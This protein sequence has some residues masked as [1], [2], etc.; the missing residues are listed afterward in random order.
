MRRLAAAL[1]AATGARRG[2]PGRGGE[3][4]PDGARLR[5]PGRRHPHL[6]RLRGTGRRLQRRRLLR[7]RASARAATSARATSGD[8]CRPIRITF[9]TP[10]AAVSL[11]AP[12]APPFRGA[13]DDAHRAGARRQGERARR[14]QA[15]RRRRTP[16]RRSCSAPADGARGDPRRSTSTARAPELAVDD[17]AYSEPRSPTRRSPRGPSGTVTSGDGAFAFAAN[18]PATGFTC[19]LDGAAS[20]PC[21]SPFSFTGLAD[22]PHTFSV[23]ATDRWGATDATPAVAHVDGQPPAA[24]AARPRRR[25]RARRLRQLPRQRQRRAGRCRRRQDRRRL[26]GAALRHDPAG[27]GRRDRR[28]R[29]CPARCS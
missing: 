12:P 1:A 17:I 26:R 16:G 7:R 8:T 6:R 20:A 15:R 22:G 3:P 24:A 18:Q 2:R 25:R 28:S 11:F 23:A 19:S 5:G 27:G 14:P 9:R 13:P 29:W 21:T 10:Q 4:A